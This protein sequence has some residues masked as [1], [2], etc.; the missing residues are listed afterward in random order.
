MG[1]YTNINYTKRKRS[2]QT[3]NVISKVYCE[4][5]IERI[6]KLKLKDKK[7]KKEMV[8]ERK[9]Y[10]PI[11]ISKLNKIFVRIRQE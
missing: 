5:K 1:G 3:T 9:E 4:L 11:E 10:K 6:D 2:I 8:N 7:E